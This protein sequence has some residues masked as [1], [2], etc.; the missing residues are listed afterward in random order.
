MPRFEPFTEELCQQ[1]KDEVEAAIA[2]LAEKYGICLDFVKESCSK[3]AEN[4]AVNARFSLTPRPDSV[5]S[6]K[7]ENDFR[8]YAESYGMRGAWLGKEF[9]RGNFTYKVAGLKIS[10]PT[11]CVI[12][13]RSDGARCQENGKLIVRYLGENAA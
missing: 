4:V 3:D 10:A 13:E 2:P 7:E 12:L 8:A 1:L 9:K 5:A 11:R 6:L